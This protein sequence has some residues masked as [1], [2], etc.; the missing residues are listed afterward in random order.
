MPKRKV[1]VCRTDEGCVRIEFWQR[2]RI[3]V[4]LW[5]RKAKAYVKAL[6]VWTS[7]RE[8]ARDFTSASAAVLYAV[9]EK[10]DF[11][12]IV[13]AFDDPQYDMILPTNAKSKQHPRRP[14]I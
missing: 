11:V 3:K 12:E 2:S 5:D 7:V 10:L 14:E 13:L 8:E 4:L 9:E 1:G 6:G